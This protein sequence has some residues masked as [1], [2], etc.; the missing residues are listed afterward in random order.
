MKQIRECPFCESSDISVASEPTEFSYAGKKVVLD[1]LLF[2]RCASCGEEFVDREQQKQNDLIYADARRS[3][4]GLMRSGEI[5]AWRSRFGLTQQD[6]SRIL[7]G[8]ANAFSKYERGEVTQSLST[9]RLMRLMVLIPEVAER[10]I[11]NNF[12][13]TPRTLFEKSSGWRVITNPAQV[14]VDRD[15]HHYHIVN[16]RSSRR[17]VFEGHQTGWKR[18]FG[19]ELVRNVN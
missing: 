9:D 6:A 13:P 1:G 10:V 5:K 18:T 15:E 3:T 17:V 12:S 16:A 8:G 7:G 19:K 11:G 4:D 2:S 14:V